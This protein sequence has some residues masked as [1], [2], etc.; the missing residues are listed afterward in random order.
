MPFPLPGRAARR[1]QE[2]RERPAASPAPPPQL[3]HR[4]CPLPVALLLGSAL[5]LVGRAQT[6]EP[7]ANSLLPDG[8]RF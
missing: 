5:A 4:P 8:G 1:S 7:G 2:A 3:R 6:E